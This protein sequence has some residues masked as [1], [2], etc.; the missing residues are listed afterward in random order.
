MTG[1]F[2]KIAVSAATYWID[3]PYDYLI[4]EKLCESVQPGVRVFIPFGK[5]NRRSEGIVLAVTEHSDYEKSKAYNRRD[6]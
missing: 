5:G 3:R 1:R 6:G 2:A 4:P